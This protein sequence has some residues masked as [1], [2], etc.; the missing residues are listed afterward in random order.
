[1]N[2]ALVRLNNASATGPPAWLLYVDLDAE[3]TTCKIADF[4]QRIPSRA[5]QDGSSCVFV[6]QSSDMGVNSGFIALSANS[7]GVRL[8][9]AWEKSQ[10]VHRVCEGPADQLA[11]QSMLVQHFLQEAGT[12]P[13]TPPPSTKSTPPPCWWGIDLYRKT[14]QYG[15]LQKANRCFYDYLLRLGLP[16][17]NRSRD[18]VCLL[19][20]AERVNMHDNDSW[21]P[22]DIF[23]HHH[24]SSWPSADYGLYSPRKWHQMRDAACRLDRDPH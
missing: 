23:F 14:L 15:H 3:Y 21:K 10:L 24:Y 22:G 2:A 5:H 20:H 13:P 8:M 19:S 11:L 6:A 18:G 16:P 17:D 1:M 4:L 9:A 7:A 12:S